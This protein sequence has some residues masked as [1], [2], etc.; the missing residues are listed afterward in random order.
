MFCPFARC[1]PDDFRQ[2]A[3]RERRFATKGGERLTPPEPQGRGAA[4]S[5]VA[6]FVQTRPSFGERAANL[7]RALSLA[8]DGARAAERPP[9][10]L[11]FP[12]LFST[13]YLFRDRD[14][15]RSFAEPAD[16]G[17]V[18]ALATLAAELGAW[19]AG[20]FAE[21][22]GNRVYNS[23][24]LVG[25]RGET[26]FYRKIHLF[27]RERETFDAGDLPF[28]AWSIE[29]RSGSAR[30]GLLICF[31]WFFPESMRSLALAGAEVALHPS[32]LVMP[33]CQEAMK[34]RCLEN[35][36]YAVTANRVGG[37][38]RDDS[39]RLAFTGRSQITGTRGEILASAAGDEESFRAVLLDLSCA[40]S[41]EL[42]R[43]DLFRDR[44]PDLYR[45]TGFEEPG[46]TLV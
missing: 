37:D 28:E 4:P 45:Q 38:R 41:K 46:S 40:R 24:A 1:E 32:N 17:T 25:P 13:G 22:D 33:W 35:R 2:R 31:D 29:T 3:H 9:D 16:G 39:L 18:A 19:V 26:R 11:V 34:T 7:D 8:R 30:V 6:A 20:G 10:V 21:R 14:E 5:I 23:A 36:V 27:D 15:T 43:N 42:G 44:R 12:E